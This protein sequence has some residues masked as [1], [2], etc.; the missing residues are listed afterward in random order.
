LEY[1]KEEGKRRNKGRRGRDGVRTGG[2][3]EMG[4][5]RKRKRNEVGDRKERQGM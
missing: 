2:G 4:R 1:G 5:R 3:E